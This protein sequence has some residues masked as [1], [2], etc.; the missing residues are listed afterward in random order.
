MKTFTKDKPAGHMITEDFVEYKGNKCY[1]KK[2]GKM[3]R[4][5]EI[6]I[7]TDEGENI[8][9]FDKDGYLIE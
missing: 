6:T 7:K 4:N 5:E 1:L 3:A 8:Y 9:S 2:S